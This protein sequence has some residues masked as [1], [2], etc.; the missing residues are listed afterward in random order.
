[1][2]LNA[3]VTG[4]SQDGGVDLIA[5]N[6]DPVFGGKYVVQCK[7]QKKTV[8][9]PTVRDLFGTMHAMGANKGI[10]ITT[11]AFTAAA[12]RFAQGK[13]L[14]LIDG[15]QYR[16]LCKKYDLAPFGA[17]TEHESF[18]ELLQVDSANVRIVSIN[19]SDP[20]ERTEYQEFVFAVGSLSIGSHLVF[21]SPGIGNFDFGDFEIEKI[22]Q[23]QNFGNGLLDR[24]SLK[25]KN[26][27]SQAFD[28]NIFDIQFEGQAELINELYKTA[29]ARMSAQQKPFNIGSKPT[30]PSGCLVSIALPIAFAIA[31]VLLLLHWL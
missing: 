26:S 14:E 8:G 27:I 19:C 5:E 22:D 25:F 16:E 18:G 2:G 4:Y 31:C 7:A 6:P 10:L 24:F 28:A 20:K 3:S 15:D 23:I 30:T 13:P 21:N 1:M 17:V 9:E 12:R 29:T 11:S